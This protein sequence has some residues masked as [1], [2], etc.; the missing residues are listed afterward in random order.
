MR[1]PDET[2]YARSLHVGCPFQ[3]DMG[4]ATVEDRLPQRV[5]H[6][7][8]HSWPNGKIAGPYGELRSSGIKDG[9]HIIQHAAVRGLPGYKKSRAPAVELPGPSTLVGADHYAA[10]RVQDMSGG[11]T[12]GAE[13]RIGYRALREAGYSQADARAAIK[14][15]D[16]Y[17]IGQL[18]MTFSTPTQVPGNR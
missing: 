5:G 16:D 12:Y 8:A 2:H 11:G 6:R 17:F 9:H 7:P 14:L 4:L 13:R 18:G 15:A 3:G 10:T 1:S